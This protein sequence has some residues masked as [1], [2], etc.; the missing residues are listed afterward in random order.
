M[1]M[2]AAVRGA[3][4][5]AAHAV[6]TRAINAFDYLWYGPTI[7]HMLE[8]RT[9]CAAEVEELIGRGFDY[10]SE[11]NLGLTPADY[12]VLRGD[13]PTAELLAAHGAPPRIELLCEKGDNPGFLEMLS[14]ALRAAERPSRATLNR[15]LLRVCRNRLLSPGTLKAAIRELHAH[16]CDINFEELSP[17]GRRENVVVLLA[18]NWGLDLW[19]EILKYPIRRDLIPV[20]YRFIAGCMDR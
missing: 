18:E 9:L 19:R 7:A 6:A 20:P 1:G 10:T 14:L 17:S 4:G 5:Q 15:A 2:L 8:H 13:G 16:N 11:N 12:A 3:A